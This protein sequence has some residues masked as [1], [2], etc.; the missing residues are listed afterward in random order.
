MPY[1]EFNDKDV[2]LDSLTD[3]TGGE[4]LMCSVRVSIDN[5]SLGSCCK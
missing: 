2:D 5:F 1:K 4:Y 3:R